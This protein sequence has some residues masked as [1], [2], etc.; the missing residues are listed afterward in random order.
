MYTHLHEEG[1]LPEEKDVE[2]DQEE[3]VINVSYTK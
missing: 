1:R 3:L 2:R